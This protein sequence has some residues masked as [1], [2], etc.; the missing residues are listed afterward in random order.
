MLTGVAEAA[1]GS[2]GEHGMAAR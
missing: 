1:L 2:G